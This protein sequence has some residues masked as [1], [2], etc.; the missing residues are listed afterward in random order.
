VEVVVLEDARKGG[1]CILKLEVGS[2]G[3]YS[4][5]EFRRTE[6]GTWDR[7]ATWRLR[8]P[9][10]EKKIWGN[11]WGVACCMEERISGK[12]WECDS[13]SPELPECLVVSLSW[14]AAAVGEREMKLTECEADMGLADLV[15]SR[16]TVLVR[17]RQF[18]PVLN[19]F[20]TGKIGTRTSKQVAVRIEW[21]LS[22]T[23]A[24]SSLPHHCVRCFARSERTKHERRGLRAGD[25]TLQTPKWRASAFGQRSYGF[26]CNSKARRPLPRFRPAQSQHPRLSDA[27]AC[28]ERV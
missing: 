22:E 15:F 1:S 10:G 12:R 25:P 8:L 4:E 2:V 19:S 13:I 14:C 28:W 16:D 26:V 3:T 24:E 5:M 20:A 17:C 7:N 21:L 9:C 6:L 23:R 27:D 11:G 18:V